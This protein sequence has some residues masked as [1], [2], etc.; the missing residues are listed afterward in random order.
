MVEEGKKFATLSPDWFVDIPSGTKKK[1]HITY[2]SQFNY[3]NKGEKKRHNKYVMALESLLKNA[4]YLNPSPNTKPLD[5]PDVKRYHYFI[6][7]AKIGKNTYKI[8]FDT[9]E[10]VGDSTIKPQTVHLYDVREIK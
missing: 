2:S 9:E 7:K 3:M 4:A 10:Y 1:K 6:T 8:I 5:K